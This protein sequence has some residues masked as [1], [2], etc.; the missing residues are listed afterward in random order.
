MLFA[1]IILPFPFKTF[2]FTFNSFI[3][4]Y[5]FN[6]FRLLDIIYIS[7]IIIAVVC[8]LIELIKFIIFKTLKT[9]NIDTDYI[10]ISTLNN[11]I[12]LIICIIVILSYYKDKTIMPY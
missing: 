12:K 9:L 5:L 3:N 10:N 6:A 1:C 8:G 4:G 2:D 11:V 7:S